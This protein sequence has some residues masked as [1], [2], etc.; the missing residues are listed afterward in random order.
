[1][2]STVLTFEEKYFEYGEKGIKTKGLAIGGYKLDFLANL[3]DPY[4]FEEGNNQFKEILLQ[5]IYRDLGLLVFKGK[6]S[7]SEIKIWREDFQSRVNKIAGK[8]YL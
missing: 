5:G 3:L 4:L 2:S 8:L 6:K 1:M 7:L